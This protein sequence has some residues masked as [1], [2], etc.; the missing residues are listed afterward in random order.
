MII[1]ATKPAFP[2]IPMADAVMVEPPPKGGFWVEEIL[3]RM[4]E[5][6]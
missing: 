6:R 1:D 5:K 4:K 2:D 3:K